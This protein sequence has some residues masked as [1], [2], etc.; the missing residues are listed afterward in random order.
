MEMDGFFTKTGKKLSFAR[1]AWKFSDVLPKIPRTVGG[2]A[3]TLSNAA[4]RGAILSRL[5]RPMI[6][7][8]LSEPV[9]TVS[10]RLTYETVL[11]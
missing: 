5:A 7:P 11:L 3:V 6:I 10:C 4:G 9:L 1:M 2:L 8:N